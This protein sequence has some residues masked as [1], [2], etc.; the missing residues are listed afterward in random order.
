LFPSY[1]VAPVVRKA[2]LDAKPAIA[3][4][5]DKLSPLLDNDVMQNLN[6]QVDGALKREPADVARDFLKQHGLA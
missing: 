2:S 5:L 4:A 1:Q 6:L 3:T